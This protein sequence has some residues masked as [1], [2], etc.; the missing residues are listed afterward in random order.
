[1]LRERT[2]FRT[3]E[4]DDD[5]RVMARWMSSAS[6]AAALTSDVRERPTPAAL[7]TAC[8]NGANFLLIL[9]HDKE[10]I[11]TASWRV[12]GNPR[13]YEISLMIGDPSHWASG[14]GGEAAVKLVDHLFMTYDARRVSALT[15]SY[16][17]HAFPTLAKGGFTLEGVLRDYYF[18]DGAYYDATIWSILQSEHRALLAAETKASMQYQPLV[19]EA[20]KERARQ[21]VTRAIQQDSSVPRSWQTDVIPSQT[22]R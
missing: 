14:L 7:R 4:S 13:S 5:F 6:L 12:K 21:M 19:P 15:A 10:P 16:N 8:E 9:Q 3:P 2:S 1:M 17:R 22:W 20:D 11:G 18:L